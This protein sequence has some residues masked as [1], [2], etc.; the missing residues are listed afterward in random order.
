MLHSPVLAVLVAVAA[1]LIVS[2]RLNRRG[3]WG[4][5]VAVAGYGLL[6]V[7]AVVALAIRG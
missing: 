6:L 4:N 7:A 2:G 1:V 3:R 5:W